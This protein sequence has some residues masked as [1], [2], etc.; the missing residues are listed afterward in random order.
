MEKTY[1]YLKL[2]GVIGL[3]FAAWVASPFVLRY[4]THSMATAAEIGNSYGALYTLFSGIA[5]IILVATLLIQGTSIKQN[6]TDIANVRLQLEK[7]VGIATIS[8][9]L[10]SLPRL[11]EGEVQ[12]LVTHHSRE[13]Y[14]NYGGTVTQFPVA[15]ATLD[16]LEHHLPAWEAQLLTLQQTNTKQTSVIQNYE[17]FVRNISKLIK[18]KKDMALSYEKLSTSSDV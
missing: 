13:L 6:A 11:I 12:H 17:C 1:D 8:A 10:V 5:V 16:T 14:G 7:Q 15:T 4:F 2:I 9:K 18:Y 3:V